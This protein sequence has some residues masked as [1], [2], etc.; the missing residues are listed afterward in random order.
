MKDTGERMIPEAHKGEL[1][2]TEHFV[3]YIFAK[4]LVDEKV[5]LDV[6]CGSGYGSK[7]LADAGAKK[8]YGVDASKEAIN[9]ATNTYSH[10]KVEFQV[11][12]AE[13]LP[14]KDQSIDVLVT[15]ETIE[16]VKRY[17][18]FLSEIKRVLKPEGLMILSTPNEEVYP[19]GNHFHL[20]EFTK[21]ELEDILQANFKY[22]LF[23]FQDNWVINRLSP[24]SGF[25]ELNSNTAEQLNPYRFDGKKGEECMYFV[26]CSS[27]IPLDRIN[28]QE[29]SAIFP[30]PFEKTRELQKKEISNL[31]KENSKLQEKAKEQEKTLGDIYSSKS[32][33][34]IVKARTFKKKL[35]SVF[36]KQ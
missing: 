26:S 12:K 33:G 7:L 8:V 20:K 21:K 1:F 28:L 15:F 9:Y 27:N 32:W 3:R 36:I 2:W 10:D 23:F 31:L 25:K 17:E 19:E 6:A 4:Q 13:N 16:H 34:I 29:V 22:N 35:K 14:I 30:Y 5:V 11:G 18:K 24:E